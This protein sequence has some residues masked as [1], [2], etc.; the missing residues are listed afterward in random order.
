[1]NVTIPIIDDTTGE[2]TETFNV[3]LTNPSGATIADGTGVVTILDNDSATG[4]ASVGNFVWN[5][6]NNNGIQDQGELGI[7]GVSVNLYT[8]TGSWAGYAQTDASG[9]YLFSNVAPGSYKICFNLPWGYS[10]VSPKD[11]GNDDATDSDVN[12]ISGGSAC[13]D[14]FTVA[15]GQNITT[16]DAGMNNG[17]PTP[18]QPTISINDIT[19]TEGTNPTATL[20]ICASATSTSPI[21][22]TYTTSNGTATSGSDYT[23][24]SATATIP[25]GQTCV[26]VTIPIIDDTTGEPTETFNVTLTNPSGAT[27]ADGTGVVTILDTDGGGGGTCNNI[28]NAG[29]IGNYQSGASPF[30]P[31]NIV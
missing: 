8:S 4:P 6:A 2:P 23:T 9:A 29:Q 3:T 13:T 18:T 20:Q 28:T 12:A 7:A 11:Q 31:A 21:T 26:N 1:V 10:N 24:V 14:V 22:V 27:I 25:A 16:I 19:V 17:T 15:A 30:D 5:D